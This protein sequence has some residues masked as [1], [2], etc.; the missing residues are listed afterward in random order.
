[1]ID[2]YGKVVTLM[3]KMKAI[4]PIYANPTR[5]L[6]AAL[7]DSGIKLK[8]KQVIQIE[9][10]LYLSDD[11]GIGCEIRYSKR[12]ESPV[13]ASITHV[14]IQRNNPLFKEIR[15]YQIERR[16]RLSELN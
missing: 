16:N 10:I 2:D 13:I 15:A 8:L 12:Q 14:K 1:M 7:Q 11:G 3:N 6:I 5:Q 9:N 4:L